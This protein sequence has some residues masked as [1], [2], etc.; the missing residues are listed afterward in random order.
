MPGYEQSF[1]TQHGEVTQHIVPVSELS[2]YKWFWR[3]DESSSVTF[4]DE[5][6]YKFDL[7]CELPLRVRFM[8]VSEGESQVLSLLIHHMVID[9]W[10]LNTLMPDL[11]HAYLARANNQEPIWDTTARS[12]NDFALQQFEQGLNQQHL[13][14][15]VNQLQGARKGLSLPGDTDQLTYRLRLN[16][17]NLILEKKLFK[18]CLP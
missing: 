11:S 13:D 10:S 6:N 4:S 8:A 2:R 15:W 7:T 14:Y 5:A 12:M 3:A 9:E 16:G 18:N 17:R 1:H